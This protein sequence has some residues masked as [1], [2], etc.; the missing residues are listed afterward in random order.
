VRKEVHTAC[1]CVRVLHS[2]CVCECECG[3]CV[4]EFDSLMHA[5]M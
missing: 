3:A 1:V 4:S 5:L 2:M